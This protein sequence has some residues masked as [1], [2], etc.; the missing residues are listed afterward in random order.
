[1]DESAK[2]MFGLVMT[3]VS[4]LILV[5]CI[6]LYTVQ[7]DARQTMYTVIEYI[8]VN[9][10][11]S[12]EVIDTINDYAEDTGTTISVVS[13]PVSEGSRYKVSVSYNHIFAITKTNR[14]FTVEGT[15]RVVY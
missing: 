11:S 9:G 2:T 12:Q 13:V 5:S 7:A 10:Y 4:A 8:E 1:M 3:F 15:T 6:T 14:Q